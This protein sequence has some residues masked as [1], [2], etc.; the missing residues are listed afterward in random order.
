MPRQEDAENA[1]RRGQLDAI[2]ALC[3]AVLQTQKA[4]TLILFPYTLK[5]GVLTVHA[6][7]ERSD[8]EMAVFRVERNTGYPAR[9]DRRRAGSGRHRADDQPLD[10]GSACPAPG[11][12]YPAEYPGKSPVGIVLQSCLYP[13]SCLRPDEPLHRFGGNVFFIDC[14][15]D[16][17][18][19]FEKSRS[20]GGDINA[21][22]L[23]L[24]QCQWNDL[25]PL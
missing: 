20:T 6:D 3:H 2:K 19:P 12:G 4:H 5:N 1:A 17:F 9:C 13:I 22:R 18:T 7:R 16:A 8:T 23:F 25:P 24:L 10:I 21:R 15:F 14:C 11:E